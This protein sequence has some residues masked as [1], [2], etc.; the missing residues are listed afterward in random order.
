MMDRNKKEKQYFTL[1][2]AIYK[3]LN[4]YYGTGY[5]CIKWA[6]YIYK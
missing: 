1:A 5:I 4:I 2:F 6:A 3:Y